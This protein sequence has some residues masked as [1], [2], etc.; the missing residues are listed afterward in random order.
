MSTPKR[1]PKIGPTY[2]I[3]FHIPESFVPVL[4]HIASTEG[5]TR[6]GFLRSL[7]AREIRSRGLDP[8]RPQQ[9]AEG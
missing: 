1:T 6:T 7:V 8:A 9:L 5:T 3:G 2:V 4:D